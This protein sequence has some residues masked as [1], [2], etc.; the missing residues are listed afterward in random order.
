[1]ANIFDGI[2][3]MTD[4]QLKIE[5]A[6]FSQVT[7]SN[8]AIETGN[9]VLGGVVDMANSIVKSLGGKSS[10]DY[11]V[12]R[13]SDMV[14]SAYEKLLHKDREWLLAEL[15]RQIEQKLG[16]DTEESNVDKTQHIE[17]LSIMVANEAAATYGLEKYDTPANK[18]EKI[19]IEYNK[20]YLQT[21][22]NILNRQTP[23]EAA[24][25]NAALQKRLDLV[26]IEA[27]RDL[28]RKIMPK[29]FSGAGIGRV[30]RLER[31][32]KNLT[33]VVEILGGECFGD[34]QT[35]A[36]TILTSVRALRR[37][38]RVL[39]AQ[40]VWQS[41]QC[42]GAKFT[43]D[44]TLL[45]S[46]IPESESTSQEEEKNLRQQ[47]AVMSEL[48]KKQEKCAE[49]VRKNEEQKKEAEEK[50]ENLLGDF[51]KQ[52]KE[53]ERLEADKERY[54]SGR[55]PESDTKRYY[56]NVNDTSRQMSN[57]EENVKKQKAKIKEIY[58]KGDRLF[59][60]LSAAKDR[61]KENKAVVSEK[62][63]LLAGELKNK[64]RAYYFRFEFEDDVFEKVAERFWR[65]ERLN[66]EELFKEIHDS[67]SFIAGKNM[68]IYASNIEN[69]GGAEG[70]NNAANF[71]NGAE[72][73]NNAENF[74]GGAE[75]VNNAAN[76]ASGTEGVN[77][78]ANSANSAEGV[79]NAANSANAAAEESL[80]EA[81]EPQSSERKTP[82]VTI[83][84]NISKGRN[85]AIMAEGN[86]IKAVELI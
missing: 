4:N 39:L 83:K 14:N 32:V 52:Q 79:G 40:L 58:E 49:A 1:M 72:G 55:M 60:E 37:P 9:R 3:A 46:Y 70:V 48:E 75:G 41:K 81:E 20:A 8:A 50:L 2:A 13:V 85:V 27:K 56:R 28:Q 36:A 30:L 71:A 23:Q 44:R 61:T 16:A 15:C 54:V 21:I 38:S 64:W 12:V 78:T 42:Y 67:K 74:A 84:C 11:D 22:H 47:L 35:H 63:G 25:T 51:E 77:N 69:A 7:L 86:V 34:I 57:A 6:L 45:P 80:R 53:F 5:I 68:E 76:F 66:I 24:K 33:Y 10:W 31:G 73:V 65:S 18:I 43:V 62:I 82:V 26:D 17:K 19:S 29:E 59:E